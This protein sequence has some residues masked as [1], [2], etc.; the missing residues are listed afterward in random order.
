MQMRAALS[1]AGQAAGRY[2]PEPVKRVMRGAKLL[3]TDQRLPWWLRLLW[4]AGAQVWCPL[5]IDEV[6]AA[7]AALITFAF[8]RPVLRDALATALGR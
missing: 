4:L 5:P 1:K 7:L 3:A 6:C 2:I 8:Y